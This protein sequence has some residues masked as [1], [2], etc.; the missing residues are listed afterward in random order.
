[1]AQNVI[2]AKAVTSAFEHARAICDWERE[3]NALLDAL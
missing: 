1:L 2:H 3:R